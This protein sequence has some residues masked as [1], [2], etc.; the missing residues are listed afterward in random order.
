MTAR[1]GWSRWRSG[2]RA[3]V[4]AAHLAPAY[5]TTI[6]K[7]QGSEYASV[8]FALPDGINPRMLTRELAYTAVTRA[9]HALHIAGRCVGVV[10][11]CARAERRSVFAFV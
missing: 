9:R 1:S 7:V 3:R 6:H 8:V 5:A 4:A 2:A 11:R 10:D